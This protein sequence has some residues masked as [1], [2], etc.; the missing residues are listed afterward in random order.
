MDF[1]TRHK[2]VVLAHHEPAYRELGRLVAD[3][4][5]RDL[6]KTLNSYLVILMQALRKIATNGKHTNV[7]QHIMGYFKEQLDKGDKEELLDVIEEYR[8]ERLPLIVPITLIKHW[9]RIYPNE[10][11]ASQYYLNPHPRELKLRN[12]I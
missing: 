2:Y 9:L 1:H 3:A 6:Q 11:I 12:Q 7:L 5:N 10:Y 8:C 4:G